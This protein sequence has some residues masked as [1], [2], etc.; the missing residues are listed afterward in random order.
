VRKEAILSGTYGSFNPLKGQGWDPTSEKLRRN[1][2]IRA[3]KLH[4][5]E[6]GFG[7]N[8]IRK[9]EG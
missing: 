5:H 7:E 1:L 2:R 6:G 3:A 4:K 8:D 9:V